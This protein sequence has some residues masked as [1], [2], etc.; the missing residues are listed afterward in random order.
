MSDLHYGCV[1]YEVWAWE[2]LMSE[3]EEITSD[4]L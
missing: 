3:G 1:E 4:K 2:F